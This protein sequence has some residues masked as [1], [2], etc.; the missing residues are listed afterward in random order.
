MN[1]GE[2]KKALEDVDDDL[3]V[4]ITGWGEDDEEPEYTGFAEVA[5]V[6]IDES[7]G[8]GGPTCFAIDCLSAEDEGNEEEDKEEDDEEG[9]EED[10][11]KS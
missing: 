1:V 10:E 7:V 9:D 8:L 3:E 4:V 5:R 6:D 2:L 11:E